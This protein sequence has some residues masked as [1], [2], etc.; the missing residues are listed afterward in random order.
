MSTM[1]TACIHQPDFAPH[2]GFFHRL[3]IADQFI[4]LDDVQFIRRGWQHRD[5]IKGRNGPVWLTLATKKGDYHQRV[6]EVLLSEDPRWIEDSLC[7]VRDC[8][9]RAP[10][11]KEV[12]TRIEGIYRAG[13]T[14]MVDFNIAFL[15]V[16]LEYF[17]INI[18]TT[19]ASQYAVKSVSSA[20]LLDLVAAVNAEVYL[21]G[22]GS[23][24]YLDVD[25]FTAAGVDVNWQAF[26]H[27]VYPQMHGA[28]CPGL[29]CIDILFNSGKAAADILRSSL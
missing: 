16:A 2:L 26:R 22:A 6:N 20:R 11:F 8:Y 18:Q 14:H 15:D 13:Y 27:P 23:K 29:S 21:T 17:Q 5:Q 12:Y 28:F 25:M 1:V 10:Y 4:L 3:L 7:L 19:F 9:A 24:N